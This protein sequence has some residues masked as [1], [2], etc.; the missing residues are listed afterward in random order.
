MTNEL[1]EK[2]AALRAVAP[3]LNATTDNATRIIQAVEDLLGDELSLGVSAE[4]PQTFNEQSEVDDD[5]NRIDTDYRLAYG[6]VAGR[7]RF[8]IWVHRYAVDEYG[9]YDHH[10][11]SEEIPWS[12]CSREDRLASFG[13]LPGLLEA[14]HSKVTALVDKA[15]ETSHIVDDLIAAL[16]GG[17]AG[18]RPDDRHDRHR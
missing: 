1:R 8:H 17:A 18:G 2:L 9:R 5:G 13:L 10:I 6:R 16:P 14:I 7:Y 11:S 12:S 4:S 15:E 3:A